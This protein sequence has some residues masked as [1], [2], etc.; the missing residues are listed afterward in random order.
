MNRIGYMMRYEISF[1]DIEYTADRT[2]DKPQVG[3]SILTSKA[4]Q[5]LEVMPTSRNL[6]PSIKSESLH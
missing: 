2:I 5:L 4:N 1:H 3:C 6:S